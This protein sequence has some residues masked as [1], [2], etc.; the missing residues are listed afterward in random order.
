MMFLE[1]MTRQ[2]EILK[3]EFGDRLDFEEVKTFHFNIRIVKAW[4]KKQTF[5]DALGVLVPEM[6]LPTEKADRNKRAV[7]ACDQYTSQPEY[8]ESVEQY[9]AN[10][11]STLHITLPELYLKDPNKS[12]RIANIQQYMQSYLTDGTLKNQGVGFILLDR[13]TSHTSSRKGLMLALD[14]EK[15]DYSVG[16][17]SLIRATEGTIL[18]RLPPRIQIR[19]EALLETPHIM[20]LIDDP[21]QQVIEPLFSNLAQYPKL[22]DFDLMM[23]GGHITG[24][25]ITDQASIQS[26]MH[27]LTQ[28]TDPDQFRKKYGIEDERGVLLFAMGDGNHSFAT[29]K[30]LR[31]EKKKS[32]TETEKATH[33]ARFALVEINNVHDEGI[34]FEP[35]HRVLFNVNAS[36]FFAEMQQYFTAL[37]SPVVLQ[38]VATKEEAQKLIQQE[39][40]TSDS[41]SH[42]ENRVHHIR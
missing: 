6:Y 17:Q 31:E 23:E 38:Y 26:V 4:I 35:I 29:A 32:L 37:D 2:I 28:L 12:Q 20:V 5:F 11:P 9:V 25:H 15:Y 19:K 40:L 21:N 36:H 14:L 18:D 27:G 22:Y 16:S 13:K 10:A 8:R 24:Y 30:A 1:M 34:T 33:P 39:V 7:V 41:S 3:A 42:Q